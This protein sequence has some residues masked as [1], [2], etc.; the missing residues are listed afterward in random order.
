MEEAAAEKIYAAEKNI[1]AT[2]LAIV[3]R[4]TS[5]FLFMMS[6]ANCSLARGRLKSGEVSLRGAK[7]DDALSVFGQRVLRRT[8]NG[9]LLCPFRHP[10]ARLSSEVLLRSLVFRVHCLLMQADLLSASG[11]ARS[12]GT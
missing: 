6:R 5:V 3:L 4:N 12:R 1:A 10:L 7:G 9:R 2:R 8:R 11:N